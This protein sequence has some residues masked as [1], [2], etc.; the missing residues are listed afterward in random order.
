MLGTSCSASSSHLFALKYNIF[1]PKMSHGFVPVQRTY[2]HGG[3]FLQYFTTKTYS[4][5]AQ[6][7]GPLRTCAAYS[8]RDIPIG[9]KQRVL[10]NLIVNG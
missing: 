7:T 1:V 6:V 3:N 5:T 2:T 8:Q 4:W 9:L 10:S